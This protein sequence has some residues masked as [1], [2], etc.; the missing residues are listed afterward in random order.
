VLN[1]LI[2]ASTGKW[3]MML[4]VYSK[5]DLGIGSSC[6]K[7]LALLGNWKWRFLADGPSVLGLASR[8]AIHPII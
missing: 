2:M 1:N 5:G 7:I 8:R 6:S 4:L 3:N